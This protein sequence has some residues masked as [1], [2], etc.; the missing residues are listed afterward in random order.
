V[1]PHQRRTRELEALTRLIADCESQIKTAAVIAPAA[2]ADI[3]EQHT[4]SL[5]AESRL[6][7]QW[8]EWAV[9][10]RETRTDV[11]DRANM[12]RLVEKLR[13]KA[14]ELDTWLR[15]RDSKLRGRWS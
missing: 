1:T 3:F 14:D 12:R 13:V 10:L 2:V 6:R 5:P 4:S 15:R 11:I 7:Q 9:T 8:L